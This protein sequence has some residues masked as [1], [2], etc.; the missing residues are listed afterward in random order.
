MKKKILLLCISL[1]SV[2][3]FITPVFAAQSTD[4]FPRYDYLSTY[5]ASLSVDSSNDSA[6]C[7]GKV[8]ANGTLN[9][10]ITCKLQRLVN[11]D[12]VTVHNWTEASSGIVWIDRTYP[13]TF[14]YRY[15]FTY[16]ATISNDSGNVLETVSKSSYAN[17]T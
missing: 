8:I 11:N 17:Y 1:C 16:T 14:G 4:I 12:W 15:R 3:L 5:T 2:L 10:S 13:V 9:I 7:T 6:N